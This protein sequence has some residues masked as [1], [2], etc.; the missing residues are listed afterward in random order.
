MAAPAAALGLRDP[1]ALRPWLQLLCCASAVGGLAGAFEIVADWGDNRVIKGRGQ[2]FRDNP[3]AAA[4]MAEVAQ[5]ATVCRLLT[6]DLARMVA[7]GTDADELRSASLC[8]AHHV[9]PCAAA[10][11]DRALELMGSAGYATEWNLERHWRDVRT[12]HALLGADV[13]ARGE[14]ARHFYGSRGPQERR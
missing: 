13:L 9:L 14:L 3:L 7:A 2:R 4:V 6:L 5:R 10:A 12:L 8:V 1:A 11:L